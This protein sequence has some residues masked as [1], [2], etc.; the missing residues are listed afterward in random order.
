MPTALGWRHRFHLTEAR[1]PDGLDRLPT[2]DVVFIGGGA[3][4]GELLTTSGPS[5]HGSPLVA[6]AVTLETEVLLTQWHGTHGGTL[7][8]IDLADAGPLG[9]KPAGNRSDRWSSGVSRYEGGRFWLSHHRHAWPACK[10]P[11]RWPGPVDAVATV[12]DQSPP[13]CRPSPPPLNL[14]LIAVSQAALAAHDRPGSATGSA[15][16]YR[17]GSVAESAALAAAGRGARL[18]VARITSPDGRAVAAIAEGHG[19]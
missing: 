15:A 12:A 18:V 19:A 13:A 3:S 6:N 17:T 9:S 16:A 10:R 1:A 7:L 11:W 8:R 5:A 2:P 14:P 4:D